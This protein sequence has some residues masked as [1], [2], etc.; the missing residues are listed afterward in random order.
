VAG[1]TRTTPVGQAGYGR[2][3]AAVPPA[4]PRRPD[5]GYLPP[6]PPGPPGKRNNSRAVLMGL[7]VG[8]IVLLLIAA[9]VIAYKLTSNANSN[10]G[11]TPP[12]SVTTTTAQATTQ[13]T[14]NGQQTQSSQGTQSV[15]LHC[16]QL[17]GKSYD[18]VQKTL[19][20]EGFTVNKV[21]QPGGQKNKV[22][23]VTP[24]QAQQGDT[25]TVTVSDGKTT[26]STAPPSSAGQPSNGNCGIG[27]PVDQCGKSPGPSNSNN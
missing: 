2:G 10:S 3:S 14:G 6:A 27:V 23:D 17:R 26:P 21:S 22:V 15:N 9:A 24:C 5:T 4:P 16:D 8:L 19:S 20:R 13:Q 11:G 7:M 18:D 12:P 25:I 1:Q